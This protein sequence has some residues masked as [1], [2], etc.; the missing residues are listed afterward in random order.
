MQVKDYAINR[1]QKVEFVCNKATSVSF[2]E[3]E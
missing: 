3:L 2:I 1:V